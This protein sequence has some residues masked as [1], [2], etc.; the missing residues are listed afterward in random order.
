MDLL[1]NS[2][3]EDADQWKLVMFGFSQC[4]D[5]CPTSLA[6]MGWLVGVAAKEGISLDGVFVS[7]DPDRDTDSVLG[8]FTS[9]F[10]KG[11]SYL[12]LE[13][14]ALESF[15]DQFAVEAVFYTKN[16]GNDFHYQVD[17]S[18]TAFLIDADGRIRVAFDALEDVKAAA[19]M[20]REK[21]EFFQ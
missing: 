20:L 15:K 17:H 14:E 19:A 13:D 18:S 3:A 8:K 21:R 5:I 6:N 16:R 4:S 12:R 2:S 10:G 9:P 1:R 7:I 11:T